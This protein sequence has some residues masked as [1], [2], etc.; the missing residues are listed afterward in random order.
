MSRVLLR[1]LRR[2]LIA[3]KGALA[4]L[5][6]AESAAREEFSD[7]R[8]VGF[9]FREQVAGSP[10]DPLALGLRVLAFGLTFLARSRARQAEQLAALQ[11]WLADRNEPGPTPES[12][13][14]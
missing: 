10:V 7:G 11:N 3:R 13:A 8:W 12:G 6:L 9:T 4:A 1:K 14:V 2:D 5:M